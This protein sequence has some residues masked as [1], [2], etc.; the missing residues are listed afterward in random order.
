[1]V[2]HSA[3][4]DMFPF[5]KVITDEQRP[6]SL[7]ADARDLCEV[8]FIKSASDFKLLMPF[9]TI[10]TLLYMFVS[11]KFENLY[12]Q[13]R[14]NRSDNTLFMHLFKSL[15]AKFNHYYTGIYNTFGCCTC[16]IEV[17]SGTLDGEL[18]NKKY[19]LMSKKIYSKRFSTDCFSDFFNKKTLKSEYGI[20]DLTEYETEKASFEELKKQNSYFMNDLMNKQDT[21]ED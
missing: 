14:F 7:G 21:E 6:E 1:M 15:T 16:Q 9:F 2:R 19:Y 10:T 18:E 17:G 12:Y 13:Y 5:V 8:V 20:E 4:V 11:K 3:T